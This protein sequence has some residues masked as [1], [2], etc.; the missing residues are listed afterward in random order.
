VTGEG[1]QVVT[2]PVFEPNDNPWS[3]DHVSVAPANVP[4]IF[5]SNRKLDV[6]EGGLHLLDIAPT[7]LELL[8][9]AIPA[10]LDRPALALR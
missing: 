3:G 8:G 7:A 4:G 6:P 9:I 10:E 5:F 2:G 1:G